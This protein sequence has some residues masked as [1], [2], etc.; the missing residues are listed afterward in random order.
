MKLE[1]KLINAILETCCTPEVA[2]PTSDVPIQGMPVSAIDS[3]DGHF[4][5][6]EL[7]KGA[8]DIMLLTASNLNSLYRIQNS[9]M[10]VSDATFINFFFGSGTLIGMFKTKYEQNDEMITSTAY[11]TWDG[12]KLSII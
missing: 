5:F 7:K 12:K 3:N 10:R 8:K 11:V 9:G 2:I 1:S 6:R 4:S